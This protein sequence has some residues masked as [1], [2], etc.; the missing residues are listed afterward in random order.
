MTPTQTRPQPDLRRWL[1]T[2]AAAVAIGALATS[3]SS[4]DNEAKSGGGAAQRTV[5]SAAVIPIDAKAA[6]ELQKAHAGDPNF[7]VL[8]VRTPGEFAQGHLATAT[9]VDFY[10]ATFRAQL[11]AM[12]KA[13]TYLVYCHSGN[14]SGQ[15]T[16][17]MRDL[18]F[19]HVYDLQGGTIALEQV[20]AE[21]VG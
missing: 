16:Q 5:Q 7:A 2:A 14:R 10:A 6:L 12:D 8:D 17:L 19:Q 1:A 21:L 4:S 13:R 11:E 3:C 20:G 9:N 18:G 15:A